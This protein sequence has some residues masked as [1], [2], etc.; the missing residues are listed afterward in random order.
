MAVIES[1]RW[2]P[3]KGIK[4][5]LCA[6][7]SH[8][9]TVTQPLRLG[10]EHGFKNGDRGTLCR[11]GRHCP[12]SV[13]DVYDA[14]IATIGK[15][16]LEAPPGAEASFILPSFVKPSRNGLV[17]WRQC[18]VIRFWPPE[19]IPG[20]R[21]LAERSQLRCFPLFPHALDWRRAMEPVALRNSTGPSLAAGT[22]G[23]P[24]RPHGA[25]A[26]RALPKG[27]T[28][29]TTIPCRGGTAG[30]RG[31]PNRGS[32]LSSGRASSPT[33]PEGRNPSEAAMQAYAGRKASA[34][35]GDD[36]GSCAWPSLSIEAPQLH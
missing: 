8:V 10:F 4:G 28:R 22:L 31:Q 25:V 30:C 34:S 9:M 17:T 24:S 35:G 1:L 26:H 21:D 7:C 23:A 32:T 5:S 13:D 15:M 2:H 12:V 11:M 18:C 20:P 33:P 29:G 27:P 36:A 14:F 16:Q 3:D 6:R 19:A